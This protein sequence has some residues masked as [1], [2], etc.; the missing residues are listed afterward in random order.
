LKLIFGIILW[1]LPVDNT[2]KI[3][4]DLPPIDFSNPLVDELKSK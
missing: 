3:I 1:V 2:G 4:M